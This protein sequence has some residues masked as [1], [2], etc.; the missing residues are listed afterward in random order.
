[1]I[2]PTSEQYQKFNAQYEVLE[3]VKD[4]IS[5]YEIQFDE[6]LHTVDSLASL[7]SQL[8]DEITEDAYSIYAIHDKNTNEI[9]EEIS[10]ID[11]LIEFINDL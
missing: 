10:D 11:E 7:D 4:R 5:I 6:T 9:V 8:V 2:I 3:T 1:M